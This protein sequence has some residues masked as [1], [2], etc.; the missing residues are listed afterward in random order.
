MLHIWGELVL[1]C[2]IL[3]GKF[4]S[5][6]EKIMQPDGELVKMRCPSREQKVPDIVILN[7]ENPVFSD[8][9]SILFLDDEEI[10]VHR[11]PV[12]F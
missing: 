5:A 11:Q 6:D 8:F 1:L 12:L 7:P 9:L 4:E 2:S 3:C 10:F